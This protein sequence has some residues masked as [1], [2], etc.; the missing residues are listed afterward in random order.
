MK[1]T[2]DKQ[3]TPIAEKGRVQEAIKELKN[4]YTENDVLHAI[5]ETIEQYGIDLWNYDVLSLELEAFPLTSCGGEIVF[6]VSKCLLENWH[7]I[8]SVR[9]ITLNPNLSARDC[10]P[11]FD[12]KHVVRYVAQD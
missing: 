8:V 10:D 9:Y 5:K 6:S 2:V 11:Y 4:T 3:Y 12:D 7:E 1:I